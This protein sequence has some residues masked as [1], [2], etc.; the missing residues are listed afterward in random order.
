MNSHCTKKFLRKRRTVLKIFS[1]TIFIIAFIYIAFKCTIGVPIFDV[2][3]AIEKVPKAVFIYAN[4]GNDVYNNTCY[5]VL[6]DNRELY[7]FYGL[8]KYE[9]HN[10]ISDVDFMRVVYK[11]KKQH[12]SKSDYNKII[13]WAYEA[14]F[15]T[16]N[17]GYG[18]SG[19][20]RLYYYDNKIRVLSY[21]YD[22]DQIIT[23]TEYIFGKFFDIT[24]F[25]FSKHRYESELCKWVYNGKSLEFV[26]FSYDDKNN[27][28]K[29]KLILH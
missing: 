10:G 11:A 3:R 15:Y 22:Y 23:N 7:T 26:L 25:D 14:D 9:N 8:C 17:D 21:E 12:I 13:D 18:D 2:P 6:F 28:S 1:I 19:R 29:N 27:P 24:K 16:K 5:Y 4:R 20:V